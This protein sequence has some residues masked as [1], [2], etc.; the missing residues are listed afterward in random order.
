MALAGLR[1]RP[2]YAGLVEL[3]V[4]LRRL[5]LAVD[6]L[7]AQELRLVGLVPD[8]PGRDLVAVAAADRGG[9]R[10]ERLRV[11][12]GQVVLLVRRRPLRHRAGERQRAPARRAPWRRRSA[13]RGCPTCPPDRRSGSLASKLGLRLGSRGRAR[14]RA[15]RRAGARG[16]TPKP[17]IW[18]SV[19]SRVAADSS[20]RGASKVRVW[21]EEAAAAAGREQ[22][23]EQRQSRRSRRME[24][25]AGGRRSIGGVAGADIRSHDSPEVA[26]CGLGSAP[27]TAIVDTPEE[28]A[29]L[30][31]PP[32]LVRRPLEA[33]LDA[34]GLGAGT[35]ERRRRS[36]R[37]TRTSRTWSARRRGVGA[38]PP[39]A[40][41]AAA[42]G[43]RRAAR[44]V[45][46]ARARAHAACACRACSPSATTTAVIGAPFYVMERIEGEVITRRA[47]RRRSTPQ[48]RSAR[49]WSTRSSRST[50]STGRRAGLEGFGKPTG[51]L[52]RQL[53]RFGGP[54]GA[55]HDA[56]G[57]RR[58]TR[59][60]RWLGDHVPESG[61]ATIVH[62]DYRLGNAMF[63]GDRLER[64][65]STG[66]SRRSA[67][68]SPTS[69]TSS[70]R[71]RRRAIRRALILCAGRGHAPARLPDP[72]RARRPLR[73]ALRALDVRRPLVHALALWK[74]AVFLEGSYKRRLAGTTDDP[75]FD[76]LKEGVPE[77]A[78]RARE[79]ALKS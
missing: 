19:A 65:S 30:E 32:L 79:T 53:R 68:R 37:V 20:S 23:G 73:G 66:S 56:R 64:R 49:S 27:M 61:P 22:R 46:A 35:V 71:G 58:S 24:G 52:E 34:H 25:R 39:A 51:Y 62:G 44:G 76:R 74:S 10:P 67:T 16:C 50:R 45:P 26:C 28:A 17:V 36:A 57:G 2:A 6:E 9:E 11:R 13:R 69:A 54:V 41:A 72:R 33:F 12:L 29:A 60:T 59:S 14:S 3:A 75:F 21:L 77:L 4:E 55:Q 7:R 78:E 15:S 1:R 42:L 31:Q 47:A 40:A 48:R 18:S 63:A 8:R 38:A 43:P 5:R 70:P